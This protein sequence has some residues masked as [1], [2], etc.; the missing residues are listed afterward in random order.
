MTTPTN[1]VLQGARDFIR[2][3][4]DYRAKLRDEL[5]QTLARA[6]EIRS[7]LK[8]FGETPNADRPDMSG[9]SSRATGPQAGS[10]ITI[11]D[12]VIQVL[13]EAP[14]GMKAG[15]LVRAVVNLRD[16][17]KPG[18]VYPTIYR[19]RDAE[20]LIAKGEKPDTVYYV[21]GGIPLGD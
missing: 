1:D 21:R 9:A 18:T 8:E 7:L 6:E 17:L 10:Q 11:P 13:S 2:Q 12:L 20:R 3:R 4:D 19:M 5:K 16:G 14:K 15:E